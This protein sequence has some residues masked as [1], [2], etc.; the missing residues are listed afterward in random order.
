MEYLSFR[1]VDLSNKKDEQIKSLQTKLTE[2]RN[3]DLIYKG[4]FL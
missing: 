3:I 2:Y 4:F 1:H